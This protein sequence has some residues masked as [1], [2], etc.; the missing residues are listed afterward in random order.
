[1]LLMLNDT[2]FIDYDIWGQHLT[3][4][5]FDDIFLKYVWAA[6]SY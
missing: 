2:Y 3:R 4:D 5:F 1:M 6:T